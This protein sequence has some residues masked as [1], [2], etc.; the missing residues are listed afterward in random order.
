SKEHDI[1]AYSGNFIW[2]EFH[3]AMIVISS[4]DPVTPELQIPVFIGIINDLDDG[5]TQYFM[6]YP[7]PTSNGFTIKSDNDFNTVKVFN[8]SG[9]LI[10]E[11]EVHSR[12]INISSNMPIGIYFVEITSDYG[13]ATQKLIVQ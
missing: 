1:I 8:Q 5:T 9:R 4:N 10:L 11:R 7:N 3:E 6:M 2:Y 13:Q 12:E